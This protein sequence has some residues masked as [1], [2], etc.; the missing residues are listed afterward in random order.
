MSSSQSAEGMEP[1]AELEGSDGGNPSASV[2]IR[3]GNPIAIFAIVVFIALVF[4]KP[5]FAGASIS[6]LCVLAEWDSVFD[7]LRTGRA[8]AYDPSLVQIFGPDYVFLAQK[9]SKGILPLWNQHSGLGYPFVADIQS[10]VFAPLRLIFDLAPSLYTYNLYL[11]LELVACAVSSFFLGRV[12]GLSRVASLFASLTY[13]FCPYNMWYMEM[14]LGASSCLFPLTALAFAHVAERRTLGSAVLAGVAAA[15]SIMSGHPECSFFA[16]A[17]SSLLM[18]LLLICKSESKVSAVLSFV[19]MLVVAGITTVAISAPALFPFAEYLLNGESYKYG[20]SYSTPV[21]CNG[22]FF[23]LFNPGQN[24]ASP[25][26]GIVAVVLAPL[27][28]LGIV[29]EEVD[30][31]KTLALLILTLLSLLLVS[32]FGPL[33]FLFSKPPFTAIITRYALPYFLLLVASLAGCGLDYLGRSLQIKGRTI[34]VLIVLLIVPLLSIGFAAL[35]SRDAS[36]MKAADFDAMLPTTALNAAALKRDVVCAVALFVAAL[37]AWLLGK[38]KP[39]FRWLSAVPIGISLL[40]IALNFSSELSVAKQSLPLQSKFF[41]PETELIHKLKD[42]GARVIST[43]EYVFRPATNAVYGVNFL[44]VHNPLF[45]KRFLS[46]LRA[47]GAKTDTFNQVFEPRLSRTLDLASVKYILSLKPVEDM[48]GNSARFVEFYK[49]KNNIW[50]YENRNAAPRAYLVA[51]SILC[52]SAEGALQKIQSKDFEPTRSVVIE[53]STAKELSTNSGGSD[54]KPEVS[55]AKSERASAESEGADAKPE[56]S[57]A[58]SEGSDW[59][60]EGSDSKLEGSDL[61]PEGSGA[62]SE[63]S[64]A[65]FEGSVAKPEGSSPKFAYQ[66]VE[67]FDASAPDSV[68]IK[69]T[70]KSSSWLV[71]TDIF[72]PGWNVYVDGR[73]SEIKRANYAF[74]AVKLDAGAHEVLFRYEPFSFTAGLLLF[75]LAVILSALA[76]KL[77]WWKLRL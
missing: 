61:K 44:T 64:D 3:Y 22:I 74:R 12:L 41:Y 38:L 32:Q 33:V 76:I 10:S 39:S 7:F 37:A 36:F 30:R 54:A 13:T 57:D 20:P 69:V 28:F 59:K 1:G 19:K 15:V 77:N 72:Y 65:K 23:N 47:C 52:D 8:Q 58:K 51:N 17:L 14:N 68:A 11:I 35:V 60:S 2:W 16:I 53:D 25:Y 26:L 48:D 21:S 5:I 18:L 43:C 73:K 6:R 67:S 56:G 9:L 24:G 4:F 34:A 63:G 62:K 46:F 71:L 70:A 31:H 42:P 49:S 40:A 75:G 29:K 50:I 66:R 27:A 55:G 45:P